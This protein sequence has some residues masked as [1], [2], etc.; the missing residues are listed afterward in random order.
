M[1]SPDDW[2]V[3]ARVTLIA[4]SF[5]GIGL[6]FVGRVIERDA[7]AGPDHAIGRAG[8]RSGSRFIMAGAFMTLSCALGA[9]V[10]VMLIVLPIQW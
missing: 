1:I 10:M 8:K 3:V 7:Q 5:L 9:V 6:L 2:K 4:L